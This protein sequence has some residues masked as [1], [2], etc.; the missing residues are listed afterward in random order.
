M[1]Y[2]THRASASVLR[3]NA[4]SLFDAFLLL[5]LDLPDRKWQKRPAVAC[6]RQRQKTQG[7]SMHRNRF[8]W[9]SVIVAALVTAVAGAAT[10]SDP[11]SKEVTLNLVAYSTPR[12]VLDKLIAEFRKTPQGSRH[13]RPRL[14]RPVLGPGPG[15]RKRAARRR[16]HSQHRQRHQRPR[17]QG[18]HQQELGQ[19]ELQRRRLELDR[20][21]R[22]AQRQPEEDQ[23]LERPAQAGRRRR[24]GEPVHRRDREVEHPRRVRRTAAA[25]Q[26]RQ[27]GDRL[28]AQVLQEQRRVA[29]LVRLERHEHVPLR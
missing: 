6:P 20:R 3:S 14:L 23:G 1:Y 21:L 25:R 5:M 19:A 4:I 17:R 9:I 15:G 11:S 2:R 13:Q 26:D 24:H 28:P 12:P 29:G 18:A 22:T 10:A 8:V 16:R 27:A 7:A